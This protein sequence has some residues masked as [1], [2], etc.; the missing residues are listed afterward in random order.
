[1]AV[2]VGQQALRMLGRRRWLR[3]RD[4]VLRLF[5]NPDS[6][7]SF[8]FEADFFGLPYTGNLN[9]FIDW[10]VF[11]YGAIAPNELHL[12]ADLA[13]R[14]RARGKPVNFF[15]VGANIG[16][17]SLFMSRHADRVFSFEPFPVVFREMQS[18]LSHAGVTNATT[19]PV[20]L[21]DRTETALFHPPTGAN[22]GTGTLGEILPD[23][24]NAESISVQVVRGDDFLAANGLPRISLLKM[25][26]EGFEEQAL[27]G[28]RETLHRDRPPILIEIQPEGRTGSG[29]SSHMRSLLYPDHLL[30][31]VEDVRGNYRLRPC[32]L[33]QTEQALVLPAELAGIV[34]AHLRFRISPSPLDGLLRR[35]IIEIETEQLSASHMERMTNGDRLCP[36]FHPRAQG[37]GSARGADGR[38]ADRLHLSRLR[39]DLR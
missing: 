35:R 21:G 7:P 32:T 16:H 11:Y 5:A 39:S 8:P 14:L 18:K 29:Q 6:H 2:T 25:D 30:F 1:M 26:V 24:A 28:L 13:A 19:F 38:H 10:T 37:G 3:G 23:N 17:H 9:N 22:Q 34:P 20:A 36:G 33:V 4:R 15:D 27:E 12:L 31:R